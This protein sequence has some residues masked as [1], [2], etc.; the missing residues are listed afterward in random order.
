MA[1]RQ[2]EGLEKLVGY[3][4]NEVAI[5]GDFKDDPSFMAVLGRIRKNVLDSM[6]N[7]DGK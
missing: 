2:H 7:S 4:A 6:A 5:V 1:N 3:F